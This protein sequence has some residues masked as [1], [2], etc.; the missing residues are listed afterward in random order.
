[1]F[2]KFQTSFYSDLW[3]Q[4]LR[5]WAMRSE[6]APGR[7]LARLRRFAAEQREVTSWSYL[8]AGRSRGTDVPVRIF[9]LFAVSTLAK[10]VI[11]E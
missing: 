1:M 4:Y 2:A 9:S 3:M 6:E 11:P 5:R 10:C 7:P 8:G